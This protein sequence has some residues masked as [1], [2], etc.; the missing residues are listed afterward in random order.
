MGERGDNLDLLRTY[1]PAKIAEHQPEFPFICLTPQCPEGETWIGQIRVLKLLLDEVTSSYSVD[2]DRIYLTGFSM[3]GYGTWG[4]AMNYPETF[5]AIAPIC[6]GGMD[7]FI[8][9]LKHIPVWAFHGADDLV[10][11]VEESQRM[12]DAMRAAGGQA[13]L[14]V[15][16]GVEHDSWTETY[17]NPELYEWFLRQRR[18]LGRK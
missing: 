5:A 9:D 14:T 18:D 16:P 17:E 1:G 13:K 3:G 12:V 15:Y 2:L 10:V 4:L 7:R 11:P 6:G 8:E